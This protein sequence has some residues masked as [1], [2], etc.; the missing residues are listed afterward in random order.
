MGK[1]TSAKYTTEWNM[2]QVI[3]ARLETM[4]KWMNM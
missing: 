1:T 2:G 4:Y 3:E